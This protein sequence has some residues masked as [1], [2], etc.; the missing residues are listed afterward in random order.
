MRT[1]GDRAPDVTMAH[2]GHGRK[3][4]PDLEHALKSEGHLIAAALALGALSIKTLSPVEDKICRKDILSFDSAT[5][6]WLKRHIEKGND[7]LGDALCRL[8]GA[9]VRR[10]NGATYTPPAIVRA[11]VERDNRCQSGLSIPA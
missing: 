5:R 8:R 2:V 4:R 3:P 10:E 1:N 7:P 6:D 11:M 9:A